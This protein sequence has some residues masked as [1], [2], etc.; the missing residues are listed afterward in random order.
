MAIVQ[1]SS[2]KYFCHRRIMQKLGDFLYGTQ[3]FVWNEF[4]EEHKCNANCLNNYRKRKVYIK[5]YK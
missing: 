5:S 4:Q 1:I 2:F 3:E